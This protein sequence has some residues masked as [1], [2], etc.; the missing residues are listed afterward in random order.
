ME[1]SHHQGQSGDTGGEG[2]EKPLQ[3]RHINPYI[4]IQSPARLPDPSLQPRAVWNIKYEPNIS[5]FFC[6]EWNHKPSCRHTRT[7][8][9]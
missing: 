1:S 9:T 7:Y 6:C 2:K 8:F 4:R 5:P 3:P